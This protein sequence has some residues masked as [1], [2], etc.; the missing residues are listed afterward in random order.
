MKVYI[1]C[2]KA[3]PYLRL[4]S[5]NGIYYT[6]NTIP[7]NEDLNGKIIASFDLNRIETIEND[8]FN[9]SKWESLQEFEIGNQ[10]AIEQTGL[11]F[12]EMEKYA[13]GKDL[14]EWH[15]EDLKILDKPLELRDF[16]QRCKCYEKG[17]NDSNC[18]LYEKPSN[19][20]GVVLLDCEGKKPITKAPQSWQYT[21]RMIGWD[22]RELCILISI[23]PEFVCQILNREK[24]IEVRKTYPKEIK[25]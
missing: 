19:K 18:L 6:Y 4:N 22:E 2:T 3:K 15:I 23:N 14:Y 17:C 16:Y 9:V 12:S 24:T 21:Y 25:K 5:Q 10:M 13:N 8:R 7:T 1:Y 20:Y 11:C